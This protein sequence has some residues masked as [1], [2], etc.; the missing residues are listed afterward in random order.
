MTASSL[1]RPIIHAL[2]ISLLAVVG[3]YV[4]QMEIH[5]ANAYLPVSFG[6][7]NVLAIGLGCTGLLVSL[8]SCFL[9]NH[10]KRIPWMVLLTAPMAILLLAGI[11]RAVHIDSLF[12]STE[13][14]QYTCNRNRLCSDLLF[15]AALL[16]FRTAFGLMWAGL[17]FASAAIA[18][19]CTHAPA[20]E[21]PNRGGRWG[22]L[23]AGGLI[24]ALVLVDVAARQE[25]IYQ[26]L[27]SSNPSTSA[28]WFWDS[29]KRV[30]RL[31]PDTAPLLA[32]L[33]MLAIMPLFAAPLMPR[34][35]EWQHGIS[36]H[37]MAARGLAATGLVGCCSCLA[38]STWFVT[39]GSQLRALH[40][41]IQPLGPLSAGH[42]YIFYLFRNLAWTPIVATSAAFIVALPLL[43]TPGIR[44]LRKFVPMA[45]FLVILAMFYGSTAISTARIER[46]VGALPV[47]D[48]D[49]YAVTGSIL[50][51]RPYQTWKEYSHFGQ[52]HFG[53][54]VHVE[55]T[56]LRLPRIRVEGATRNAKLI[57]ISS[58]CISFGTEACDDEDAG[59]MA[60]TLAANQLLVGYHRTPEYLLS[61]IHRGILDVAADASTPMETIDGVRQLAV[62]HGW[63]DVKFLVAHPGHE[64]CPR[65]RAIELDPPPELG[66]P[67]TEHVWIL[68]IGSDEISLSSVASG[69]TFSDSNAGILARDVQDTLAEEHSTRLLFVRHQSDLT[70]GEYLA[71]VAPFLNLELFA[72]VWHSL[73]EVES[74]DACCCHG[75]IPGIPSRLVVAS[76]LLEWH[77][78][79]LVCPEILWTAGVID[80]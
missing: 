6:H 23:C 22:W 66:P 25:E 24:A 26:Y 15:R 35:H 78:V 51:H 55:D 7:L 57:R 53:D 48:P 71:A 70:Y 2:C 1:T 14:P 59:H 17:G 49:L 36:R 19:A 27:F 58:R 10:G 34:F 16:E 12:T 65:Y 80:E 5:G 61:G 43:V 39:G 31:L 4:T 64:F 44:G 8:V 42:S 68:T 9:L 56:D 37:L 69:H 54:A 47:V 52:Y 29:L 62:I 13:L 33:L 20:V 76:G 3:L 75:P 32:A 40:I 41:L 45:L 73:S 28:F 18:A 46:S 77:Q 21:K 11:T 60:P 79:P 67:S 30:F 38:L 74:Q 72:D 50:G 63:N